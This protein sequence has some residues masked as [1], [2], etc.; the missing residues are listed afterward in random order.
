MVY[1][2]VRRTL[3]TIPTSFFR[4]GVIP[5]TRVLFPACMLLVS[6]V[7]AYSLYVRLARYAVHVTR[8]G[9]VYTLR[10]QKVYVITRCSNITYR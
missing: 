7:H 8:N 4:E 2:T 9:K 3:R 10:Y 5:L 1:L 6:D